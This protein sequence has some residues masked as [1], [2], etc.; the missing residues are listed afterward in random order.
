LLFPSLLFI[1]YN[2]NNINICVDTRARVNSH[3]C[4]RRSGGDG[5]GGDCG[6]CG[7]GG[8]GFGGSGDGGGVGGGG[9]GR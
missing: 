5:V 3:L 8:G 2:K 9:V 4:S 6:G 7:R 1:V